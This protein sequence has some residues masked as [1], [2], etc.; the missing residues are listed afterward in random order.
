MTFTHSRCRQGLGRARSR[1]GQGR[2]RPRVLSVEFLFS[3]TSRPRPYPVRFLNVPCAGGFTLI[4]VL[5]A[6]AIFA[7]V[8]A[9]INTVFYSALRLRNRSAAAFD[10]AL[11]VQQAVAIIKRDLANL[12]VPGGTLSGSLQTTTITNSVVGQASPDFYTSAGLMDDIVPWGD[13][14]RVSY[15]LVDSTNRAPGMDLYRAV[16]RNL[17]SQTQDPPVQQRLMGGVQ[18]L[19]FYFYD[20]EQWLDSWDSAAQLCPRRSNLSS[21]SMRRSAPIRRSWPAEGSNET[22]CGQDSPETHPLPLPGGE[23]AGGRARAQRSGPLLK[24]KPRKRFGS[25]HRDLGGVWFGQHRPVLRAL[26][27][28]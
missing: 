23:L 9:A 22:S 1:T 3:E 18:G 8:L 26:H 19:V 28:F 13:I 11:P 7:I 4:E 16:T 15:L 2:P 12:V 6:V 20:G 24:P 25:D 5:I 27:V 17:L 14:E 21:R 10:E